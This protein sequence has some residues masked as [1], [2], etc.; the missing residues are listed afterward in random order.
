MLD[1][2]CPTARTAK[3]HPPSLPRAALRAGSSHHWAS[4]IC[5]SAGA[6][7]THTKAESAKCH[8]CSIHD[9]VTAKVWWHFFL[10][11]S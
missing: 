11:W 8:T 3:G 5:L 2:P 7:P 9:C 4:W 10:N 6:I 1:R